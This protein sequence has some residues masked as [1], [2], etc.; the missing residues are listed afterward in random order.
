ML[1]LGDKNS[2]SEIL[3]LVRDII[4]L[5]GVLSL[6]DDNPVSGVLILGDKTSFIG[7]LS[8][9]RYEMVALYTV[10][11]PRSSLRDESSS[12]KALSPKWR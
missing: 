5:K 2:F 9:V 3:S 1:L 4:L 6:G 11:L 10:Y 7:V 12:N 8:L